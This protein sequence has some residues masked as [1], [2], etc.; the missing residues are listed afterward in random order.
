MCLQPGRSR[1]PTS[2]GIQSCNFC[3]RD[4]AG[5]RSGD[6]Q[7]LASVPSLSARTTV[8]PL[9]SERDVALIVAAG[10]DPSRV[11]AAEVASDLVWCEASD[12]GVDTVAMKNDRPPHSPHSGGGRRGHG[13]HCSA[14]PARGVRLGCRSGADAQAA[15]ENCSGATYSMFARLFIIQWRRR[16]VESPRAA[17]VLRPVVVPL[18]DGRSQRQ[19]HRQVTWR[20]H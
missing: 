16:P 19:Q 7:R 14:R 12:T 13:G 4:G 11:S 10:R 18:S 2:S 20:V 17:G 5:G 1:C 3:R 8:R 9:L 15:R 6:H